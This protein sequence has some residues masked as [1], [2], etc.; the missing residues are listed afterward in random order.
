[1]KSNIPRPAYAGAGDVAFRKGFYLSGRGGE[2]QHDPELAGVEGLALEQVLGDQEELVLVF[3]QQVLAALVARVDD[4]A[5]LR[6]N[7][8]GHLLAVAAAFLDL[9]PEEDHL[10]AIAIGNRPERVAHPV[11]AN[12]RPRN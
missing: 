12:H 4:P 9:A 10:L 2:S 1:M 7:R 3:V 8:F 6:V 11:L 5:D